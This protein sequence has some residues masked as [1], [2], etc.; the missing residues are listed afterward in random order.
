MR[1]KEEVGKPVKIMSETR[2][3]VSLKTGSQLGAAMLD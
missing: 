2:R 3:L 1:A